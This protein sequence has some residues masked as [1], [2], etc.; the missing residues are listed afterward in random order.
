[1]AGWL[2]L[3]PAIIHLLPVSG[4]L[5]AARLE[6]LYGARVDDPN[7][8]LAMRH[9]ALMFGGLGLGLLAAML[10]EPARLPVVAL[11]VLSDAAFAA[12]ALAT[13][14]RSPQMTRVLIADGVSLARLLPALVLSLP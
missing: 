4:V 1:M 2:L 3:L 10:W 5:G 11:T 12:L 9:R 14:E 8:L 13:P 7:L 6:K